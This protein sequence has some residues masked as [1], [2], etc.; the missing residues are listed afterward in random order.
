MNVNKADSIGLVTELIA[1]IELSMIQRI[2]D[3]KKILG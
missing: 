1:G 2:F 3:Q